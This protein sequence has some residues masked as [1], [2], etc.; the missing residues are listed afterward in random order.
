MGCLLPGGEQGSEL[1]V[2]PHPHQQEARLSPSQR[3][4]ASK[5]QPQSHGLGRGSGQGPSCLLGQRGAPV[6]SVAAG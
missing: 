6:L 3:G 1:P 5:A 4:G 2:A